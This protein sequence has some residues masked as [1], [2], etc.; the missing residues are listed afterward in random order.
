MKLLALI[1]SRGGSK[2]IVGKNIIPLAG[3]PLIAWTIE[4]VKASRYQLDSFVSTDDDAI[5]QVASDYGA[6]T[7]YRRPAAL[8][9]DSATTVDAVLDGLSWLAAQNKVYDAIILLQ[10]TSPLRTTAQLDAAIAQWLTHDTRSLVSVCEPTHP[11]YLIFEEQSNG[12]WRGLAPLPES[13]RRQDMQHRY[14][15]LNGAIFIQSTQ[16][17][18][19]TKRFFEPEHSQFF[20][21][22]SEASIDI[23]SPL[24]LAMAD[25]QMQHRC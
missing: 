13:G 19:E 23:D 9:S 14:A 16:R 21:M 8:A 25:Y 24:D 2:G 11:P 5:A 22:P 18:I 7:T 20:F 3:K 6:P 1:P 4:A 17:L 15:Q 12:D 10:P